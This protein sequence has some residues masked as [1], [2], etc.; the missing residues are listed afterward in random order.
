MKLKFVIFACL[1]ISLTSCDKEPK[2]VLIIGD[3]ISLGYTPTVKSELAEVA[4]VYHNPGGPGNPANNGRY[5][6]YGL[7]YIETFVGDT[8][9]WDVIQ[10][11]W[12][13][14]DLCYAIPFEENGKVNRDKVNGVQ[15][16]PPAQYAENLEKLVQRLE[17]TGAEL[18]WCTT[19]YV[20]ENE[21]GRISGDEEKYNA[22]ALEI[23]EKHHVRV[24]DIHAYSKEVHRLHARAEND[25]HYKKEGSKLLGIKV[26]DYL[27]S[28][29]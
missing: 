6:S 1:L 3:S 4:K 7:K 10:F 12:G 22:I 5:T 27:R 17:K 21:L 23:M 24:N 29:L 15:K 28:L 13:L 26:A 20:P 19:S 25:V 16:T 11:N 2:N 18:V 8:I 9:Q 14:W